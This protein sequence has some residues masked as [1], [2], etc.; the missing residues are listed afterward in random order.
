MYHKVAVP[1]AA[2]KV[3]SHY[4]HPAAFN[5]QLQ[6]L[7]SLGYRSISPGETRAASAREIAITFDDG[8]ENFF[9]QAM[10]SLSKAGLGATVFVVTSRLGRTDEWDGGIEPLM[11]REQVLESAKQGIEIGSHTSRHAD[12][13]AVDPSIAREEIFE[14]RQF[15]LSA[16]MSNPGFCYPYGRHNPAIRA[17]VKAAGYP[18]ACGTQRGQNDLST[19]NFDLHRINIRADTSLPIFLFKLFRARRTRG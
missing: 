7:R 15:L 6:L 19:D 3:R 9:T 14:S 16:G 1:G 8:Y 10:P 18:Y 13:T 5:R 12:L 2:A 17:L 11:T 4:V